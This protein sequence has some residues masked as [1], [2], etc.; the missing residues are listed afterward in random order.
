MRKLLVTALLT[1]AAV[2]GSMAPASAAAAGVKCG[3]TITG[4]VRLRSDLNCEGVGLYLS[5]GASLD[6][7]GHRLKGRHGGIALA[8][9]PEPQSTAPV[10]VRNGTVAGWRHVFSDDDFALLY[11]RI[12]N[13]TFSGIE[14][15]ILDSIYVD[16]VID[17]SSFR[18]APIGFFWGG[19]L[20]V[21]SSS[22]VDSDVVGGP[23]VPSISVQL[24]SFV[25]SRLEGSCTDGG[26]ITV[27]RSA[28]RDGASGLDA[29]ACGLTVSHSDFSHLAV[30]L[31]ADK[32]SGLGSVGT[33]QLVNNTFRRNGVALE[34][35]HQALVRSNY[36]SR[37]GV[38]VH[39]ETAELGDVAVEDIVLDRNVF[40][41]NG[42]GVVVDSLTHVGGNLAVWNTRYGLYVPRAVD[43]GRN[44]ARHNGVDCVGVA[45]S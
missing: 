16:A 33:H 13:V 30:A 37:N 23:A 4:A 17:R 10:S 41:R 45:C 25:R 9:D 43:R 44:V 40:V 6:L 22:F 27:T 14:K 19:S 1:M 11:V 18:Q 28:F 15:G 20:A 12:T 36:F 7:G 24:S 3:D 35:N 21:R 31:R 5:S 2:A 26:S 34:L 29:G 32:N 8:T 42:D 38:G 39:S